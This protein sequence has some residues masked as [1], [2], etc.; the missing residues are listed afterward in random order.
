MSYHGNLSRTKKE[1]I[2]KRKINK[3][4]LFYFAGTLILAL[5]ID[6]LI[7]RCDVSFAF[8][9]FNWYEK[10]LSPE[11]ICMNEDKLKHHPSVSFKFQDK[12]YYAC[13]TACI[14]HLKTCEE[15]IYMTKDSFSG[16]I[17]L[18]SDAIYGL[19]SKGSAD[20][21]YFTNKQNFDL[22]YSGKRNDINNKNI[23]ND[24]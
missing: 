12:V 17:I 24:K 22:Y 18:K 14:K 15:N 9:K 5:L 20:I 19:K 2:L 6:M 10:E 7:Y 21:A 23:K 13:T 4:L 16:K 11:L 3:K 8:R 1:K